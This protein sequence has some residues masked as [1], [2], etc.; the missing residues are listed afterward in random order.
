MSEG[1]DE[2]SLSDI[3]ELRLSSIFSGSGKRCNDSDFLNFFLGSYR[4]VSFASLGVPT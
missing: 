1:V 4:K 2:K 3:D